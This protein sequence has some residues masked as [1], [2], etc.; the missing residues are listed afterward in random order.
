MGQ[1]PEG[2]KPLTWKDMEVQVAGPPKMHPSTWE[3]EVNGLR[4]ENQHLRKVIVRLQGLLERFLCTRL[5]SDELITLGR[6]MAG[7]MGQVSEVEAEAKTLRAENERLRGL[8]EKAYHEGWI[9]GASAFGAS[10]DDILDTIEK[11]DSDWAE[12]AISR[13]ALQEGEI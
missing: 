12:V 3:M 1:I 10:E 7:Q 8:V 4:A 2:R 9:H 13:V 11:A 6:A 5:D